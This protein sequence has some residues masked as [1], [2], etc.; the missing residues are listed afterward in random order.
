MIPLALAFA[1]SG[2]VN[3]ALIKGFSSVSDTVPP[4]TW[5]QSMTLSYGTLAIATVINLAATAA[6]SQLPAS[7]LPAR[8]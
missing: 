3:G 1:V 2:A 5:G 8:R 7:Q 6:L 4:L